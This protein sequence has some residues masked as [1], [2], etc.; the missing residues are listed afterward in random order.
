MTGM[1]P[2][3]S[4]DAL[5]GLRF[6]AAALIVIE[7]SAVFGLQLPEF[8]YNQGV[9]FFFVL[10][11]FILAYTYPKVDD[12]GEAAL[13]ISHR[14]ARIWPDHVVMLLAT[15]FILKIPITMAFLP[16][17]FLVQGWVPSENYFFFL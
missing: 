12:A 2:P 14:I 17:L 3:K 10:S 13:F 7:H 5:T 6:I 15:V 9:S 11:G 1:A 4:L 8:E 16:N